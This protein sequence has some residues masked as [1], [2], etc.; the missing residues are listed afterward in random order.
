MND[1]N[2]VISSLCTHVHAHANQKQSKFRAFTDVALQLCSEVHA[3][4][5]VVKNTLWIALVAC[6]LSLGS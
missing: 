2:K 6:Y 1:K 5:H 4:G 3:H